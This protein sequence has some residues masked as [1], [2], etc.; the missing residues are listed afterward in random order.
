MIALKTRLID[1][2][3]LNKIATADPNALYV[4]GNS[5]YA[6]A[7]DFDEE[8]EEYDSKTARFSYDGA[9]I[10]VVFQGNECPIPVLSNVYWFKVGVFAGDLR[11]TTPAYVAATKSILCEGGS[12]AAPSDD[13]YNQL[14]ALINVLTEEMVKTINGVEPDENGNIQIEGGAGVA[15][16]ATLTESGKA[17]DAAVVGQRITEIDNAIFDTAPGKNLLNPSTVSVGYLKTDGT[18]STYGSNVTYDTSDYIR[19]ATN[20]SYTVTTVKNTDHSIMTSTKVVH[21]YDDSKQSIS[22]GHF[23]AKSQ[24]TLTFNT[25]NAAYVRVSGQTRAAVDGDNVC[26]VQLEKGDT[27]T[28]YEPYSVLNKVPKIASPGILYGKKYVA[29]GDSFTAGDFTGYVDENGLSGKNSPVLYD[30]DWKMYKTYPWWIA[31]RNNMTLVLDA[32]NGTTM[33]LTKEY[34]DDPAN[35]DIA[36]WNPFS[37]QRYTKIPSDADYITIWFG[38]NDANGKTNLGTIDDT[39]N[40]TF[41]GAW[42]VVLEY[43]LINHPYAKVGIV[44]TDGITD[45]QYQDA[46]REVAKKWGFPYLDLVA[47][48]QVP[49]MINGRDT[50]MGLCARAKELR[51]AAFK[52]SADNFHP[53]IKAH[54]YRST[55]IENWL[56]TL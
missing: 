36:T 47:D 51:N 26:S 27:F 41:Y 4:C 20:T 31:K 8:W 10:D 38:L 15:V 34:L 16:D 35:V 43:L 48:P 45:H 33:A 49:A 2:T 11:T 54:E 44:V 46:V 40:T 30:S 12:P 7:F 22:G 23:E 56:R 42:N 39:D 37:Y 9:Y 21:L 28:G 1:V 53:G 32:Q 5:D 50:E 29:C 18:L 13:V 3:V 6:V 55:I 25:G 17:A 24:Q 14:M 52:V 19:V